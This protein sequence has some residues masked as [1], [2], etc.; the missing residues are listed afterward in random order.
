MKKLILLLAVLFTASLT[1]S[2]TPPDTISITLF[3]SQGFSIQEVTTGKIVEGQNYIIPTKT[4][5]PPFDVY[6]Y[7]YDGIAGSKFYVEDGGIDRNISIR[8]LMEVPPTIPWMIDGKKVWFL[9]VFEVDGVIG[10]DFWFLNNKAAVFEMPRTTQFDAMISTLGYTPGTTWQ[11]AYYKTGVGFTNID[12]LTINEPTKVTAKIS[13][14]SEIG[15]G[16]QTLVDVGEEVLSTI[17]KDFEL[18]QNYPNPFNPGTHI[19]YSILKGSNVSLKVYNLLGVEVATLVDGYKSAGSYRVNF[20][21][22]AFGGLSSGVYVY[23]LKAI[24]KTLSK[25]MLLTK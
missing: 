22:S 4:L 8:I 13:H 2:Q 24:G 16:D 5:S 20:N 15:A 12:I 19:E 14:F 23:K 11:F 25:K 3:V 9:G 7:Y 21:A 1:Y 18:K 10:A 6:Q 17:P